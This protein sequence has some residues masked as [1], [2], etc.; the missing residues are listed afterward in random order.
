M[1]VSRFYMH[2]R[3]R[4]GEMLDLEGTECFDRDSLRK[5]VLQNARDLIAGD[6]M[7]GIIDLSFRI[8]AEDASGTLVHSLSFADAVKVT[9]GG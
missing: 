3:N 6:V 5:V 1:I 4:A 7:R 8:D 2:L 9:P